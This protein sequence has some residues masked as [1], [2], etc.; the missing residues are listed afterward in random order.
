MHKPTQTLQANSYVIFRV[1]S[2]GLRRATPA[3]AESR[4]NSTFKAEALL[5]SA[6]AATEL[7]SHSER[8]PQE[9]HEA[10]LEEAHDTDLLWDDGP[11]N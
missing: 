5:A 6:T 11:D 1:I 8:I 2:T 4:S 3:L 10:Q 9:Q 7:P